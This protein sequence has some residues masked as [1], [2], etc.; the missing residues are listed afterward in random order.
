MAAFQCLQPFIGTLLAF[1]VLNELPTAWD[2]GAVGIVAGL[3]LVTTDR[4]DVDT[5]ALLVRLKRMLS[6]RNLSTTSLLTLWPAS[7]DGSKEQDP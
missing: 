3:V 5:S 6:Q 1:L 7:A 4:R 2:L